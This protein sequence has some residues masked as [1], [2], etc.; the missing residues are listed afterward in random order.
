MLKLPYMKFRA[1]F[2]PILCF[3]IVVSLA[4]FLVAKNKV[5]NSSNSVQP[6]EI[7]TPSG[8]E[9]TNV[10]DQTNTDKTANQEDNNVANDSGYASDDCKQNNENNSSNQQEIDNTTP[11][12]DNNE[13]YTDE[14]NSTTPSNNNDENNSNNISH[15]DN[16]QLTENYEIIVSNATNNTITAKSKTVGIN[17][18][19]HFNNQTY[20]NQD[21]E[22]ELEQNG[23]AQ[24]LSYDAPLIYLKM[25]N[26][27][28]VQLK[29]IMLA[30]PSVSTTITI[31]FI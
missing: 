2:Y 27:G 30:N 26:K 19:I 14:S 25:L 13:N 23:V 10:L 17:Y 21:V 9:D 6:I 20:V 3:A 28:S 12:N 22:V 24:I 16:S 4:V 8:L 29:I 7:G 5:E 11:S 1:I 15:E 31:V 18:Q